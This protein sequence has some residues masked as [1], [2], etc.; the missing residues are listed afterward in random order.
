MLSVPSRVVGLVQRLTSSGANSLLAVRVILKHLAGA[1]RG[2]WAE[3]EGAVFVVLKGSL[4]RRSR[5]Y[6]PAL[7]AVCFEQLAW[8]RNLTPRARSLQQV[9]FLVGSPLVMNLPG[10]LRGAFFSLKQ[11]ASK[12]LASVV[13][14]NPRFVDAL[15]FDARPGSPNFLPEARWTVVHELGHALELDLLPT[16]KTL[17]ARVFSAVKGSSLASRHELTSASENFAACFHKGLRLGEALATGGRT[18]GWRAKPAV[19]AELCARA[20]SLALR[21]PSSLPIRSADARFF[22]V[23]SRL[24]AREGLAKDLGALGQLFCGLGRSVREAREER[25]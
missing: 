4:P 11:P 5:E 15:G 6:L 9:W 24:L 3:G 22:R 13:V 18:F 21:R 20:T 25:T 14:I 7:E 2:D 16:G 8:V 17:V 10:H 12:N 23:L 19:P 1:G